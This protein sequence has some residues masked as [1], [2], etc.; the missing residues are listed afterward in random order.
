CLDVNVFHEACENLHQPPLEGTLRL[1]DAVPR[2]HG[3]GP[4]CEPGIRGN[5]AKLLLTPKDTLTHGIPSVIKLSFVLVSPLLENVM[6]TMRCT[7]RPVHEKRLVRRERTLLVHPCNRL[8][9]QV[10]AQMVFL[11]SRRFDR[12]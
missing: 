2:G 12:V 4:W 9:C 1:R 11:V 8:V 10:L 5:P 7:G 6:G 3:I